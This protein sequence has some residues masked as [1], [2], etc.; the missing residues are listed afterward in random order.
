MAIFIFGA[1]S[2]APAILRNPRFSPAFPVSSLVVKRT[3]T[4]TPTESTPMLIGVNVGILVVF[5]FCG[6]KSYAKSSFSRSLI[7]KT[8][9]F[10]AIFSAPTSVIFLRK[11]ISSVGLQGPKS[12]CSVKQT[13]VLVPAYV[14]QSEIIGIFYGITTTLAQFANRKPPQ[15]ETPLPSSP[16]SRTPRSILSPHFLPSVVP[17]FQLRNVTFQ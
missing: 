16:Q 2:L 6:P 9:P 5:C 4:P 3:Q 10:L 13:H 15:I 17:I 7:R 12:R 8:P 11:L 1:T 14:A